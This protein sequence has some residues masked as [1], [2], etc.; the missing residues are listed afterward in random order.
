MF[1]IFR[2]FRVRSFEKGLC[3]RSGEFTGVLAGGRRHWFVDPLYRVRVEVVSTREPL[4]RHKDL[5]LIVK[6]GALEGH[7]EVVD[8]KDHQRGLV[9]IDGRFAEVL[10]PGAHVLWTDL[11]QVRVE[12]IDARQVRFEHSEL[13]TILRSENAAAALTVHTVAEGQVGLLY[14]DGA[15]LETLPPGQHACWNTGQ[16]ARMYVIDTREMV[17]DVAGQEIMTADKVTLR[18]NAL[19]T[20]RVCNVQQAMTE[21]EDFKQALY[22]EAQM[23]LRAMVGTRELDPLLADKDAVAGDLEAA[24]RKRA[25]QFGLSVRSLGIRDIILPGEMKE[26][27]NRVTEAKKAAEASVITR[28]EETA[29]MRSQAN[30]AKLL[31]NN[32]TLMRLRELEAMER[33][34]QTAKLN[35]FLGQKGLAESLVKLV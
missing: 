13:A 23:I 35:V 26:L 30:T 9:W 3:Y 31:D 7:A 29:A 11:C 16:A 14:L 8:L 15:L 19:V 32:P 12:V 25:G 24:L 34:A 4:L 10:G 18:I 6:S 17:L 22:R 5:D 20:Y 28:R 33:V 27:L 1:P 2:S 21:V